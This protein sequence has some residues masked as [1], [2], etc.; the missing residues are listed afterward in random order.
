M[1][2]VALEGG[3][4]KG[5]YHLGAMKAIRECNIEIGG[6]VGTSI[7]ALNAAV[8]A[9]G[10]FEKLYDKW[11]N[12]G[13]STI[14]IDVKEKEV[15]K[16]INKKW[17]LKTI[18]YWTNFFKENVANKGIDSSK[19]KAL[20]EKMIDEEKLRTS[21]IDFGMVTVSL[22]DRKPI[23][24]YKED[25]KEGMI[26]TYVLAS[27]YLPVFRQDT[28]LNDN[29]MYIDGGFYDNCPTILLK[30]KG[31]TDIIEIRT[32]AL[33]VRKR[34]N[35]KGLNIV[36]IEASKDLGNIV[37]GDNATVRN[38]MQMGYY[39][40]LRVLKGYIGDKFYVVPTEN[41]KVFNMLV[42]LTDEQVLKI[43]DGIKVNG[44]DNMEP[45]KILFEKVLP[46][47]QSKLKSK[48]TTTYQ[49][50]IVSMIEYITEDE[51][52][53]YKLYTFNELLKEFKKKIPKLM[54]KEKESIIKNSVNILLLRL[55]KELN[56]DGE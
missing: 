34:I 28:I 12:E 42:S 15:T 55:I 11:Y 39:D 36:R 38:D 23:Y 56:I 25:I 10:D 22:T 14:G 37:L 50:M 30:K 26:A 24:L 53:I 21:N 2:G 44:I 20:Y 27:S 8:L 9:Q 6:Y 45:K 46:L 54:K 4:L 43:I 47:I 18:K 35:T 13:S 31:Y 5:A 29:K 33:G 7:G 17:D 49:K 52:E 51:L 40:A 16:L 32:N 19:L 1:Y 41:E 48:D 3:G